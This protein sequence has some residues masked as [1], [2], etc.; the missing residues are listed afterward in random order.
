MRGTKYF[1]ILFGLVL[2]V[3]SVIP[4]P[5][6]LL[7]Q[8]RAGFAASGLLHTWLRDGVIIPVPD[9]LAAEPEMHSMSPTRD[10]A[11]YLEARLHWAAAIHAGAL[12]RYV[13]FGM[14]ATGAAW[15]V[16]GI[17]IPARLPGGR[18]SHLSPA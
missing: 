6:P 3:G 9:K 18:E 17:R 4:V 14:M 1:C 16:V 15:I 8:T 2:L 7:F 12:A 10:P 13:W 11:G 5:L